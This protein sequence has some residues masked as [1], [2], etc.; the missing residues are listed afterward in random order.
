M[1]KICLFLILKCQNIE[2]NCTVRELE[3]EIEVCELQL[4]F[5][6]L[7]FSFLCEK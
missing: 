4:I 3:G 6:S 2:E 7:S 1:T 5:S